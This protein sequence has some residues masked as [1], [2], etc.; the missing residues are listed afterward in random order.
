MKLLIDGRIL[1]HEHITG[2]ER[3]TRSLINSFETLGLRHDI[4]AP[5]TK[6]KYMQHLWEHTALPRAARK[7]DILFCPANMSPLWKPHGCKFVLT[8]HDISFLLFPD[9]YHPLYRN[10]YGRATARVISIANRIITDSYSEKAMLSKYFPEHL[11]KITVIHCGIDTRFFVQPDS[12]NNDSKEKYILYVGTLNSRKNFSG[13]INAFIRICDRVPHTLLIAGARQ[14]IYPC[15]NNIENKRIRYL[16]FVDDG[17]LPA[18]YRNA[19]LFVFP[20]FYEG[21]GFPPLEAMACGC[22]V[23]ASNTSSLPEICGDAARLVDPR[24]TEEIANAMLEVLRNQALQNSMIEAGFKRA[25]QFTWENTA[26]ATIKVFEE[27]T[28]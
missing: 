15:G 4:Y 17:A 10:Y 26:K 18:L 8:I 12:Q 21:F 23:I 22:P 16:G 7:Y 13:I 3:Y 2:V 14:P 1:S 27:V 9:A 6:N 20:S 11:N 19:S 24:N 25:S 28:Q 5:P